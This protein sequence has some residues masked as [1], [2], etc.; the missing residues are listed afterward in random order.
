MNYTN[1]FK[2]RARSGFDA[3]VVI[4][5]LVKAQDI[6]NRIRNEVGVGKPYLFLNDHPEYSE[7]LRLQ[8]E[9][10]GSLEQRTNDILGKRGVKR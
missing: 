2:I 3:A 1:V 4:P 8:A 6:L 10:M 7:V 5:P 9:N